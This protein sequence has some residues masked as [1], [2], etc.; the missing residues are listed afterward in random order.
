MADTN[1]RHTP[2]A[3][4]W[5]IL[6]ILAIVVLMWFLFAQEAADPDAMQFPPLG[7]PVAALTTPAPVN[8]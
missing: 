5:W 7:Q 8:A 4:V 1:L 6:G 2:S 3:A